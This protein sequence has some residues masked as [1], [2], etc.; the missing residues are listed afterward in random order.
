MSEFSH[1]TFNGSS[2]LMILEDVRALHALS[3]D[4]MVLSPSELIVTFLEANYV[5][6]YGD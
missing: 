2:L 6:E 5:T 1:V 4:A 3:Y